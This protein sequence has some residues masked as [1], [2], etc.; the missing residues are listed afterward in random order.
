MSFRPSAPETPTP[1]LLGPA[2]AAPNPPNIKLPSRPNIKCTH[3]E[4]SNRRW[5]P[6]DRDAKGCWLRPSAGWVGG[7]YS[8]A[9]K[10]MP[11]PA[12][13]GRRG[14]ALEI[15]IRRPD[16]APQSTDGARAHSSWAGSIAT[17]RCCQAMV[18]MR[19]ASWRAGRRRRAHRLQCHACIASTACCSA[20]DVERE[21]VVP[22]HGGGVLPSYPVHVGDRLLI[23]LRGSPVDLPEITPPRM[24]TQP[25]MPC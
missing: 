19:Q 8:N 21:G 2:A 25:E 14:A 5:G 3:L 6:A 24:D 22:M 9:S 1:A 23:A 7:W 10:P 18:G 4:R 12:A 15:E 17:P 11:A 16:Q 20:E 13:S